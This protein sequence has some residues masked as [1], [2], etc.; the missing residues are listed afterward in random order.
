MAAL[1]PHF[2]EPYRTLL[3]QRGVVHGRVDNV[4]T[5]YSRDVAPIAP[6][7]ARELVAYRDS[8]YATEEGW[9]FANPATGRLP[10]GGNSEEAYSGGG[11]SGRH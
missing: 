3:V 9:L 4:K 11:K 8:H 2:R 7:L 1:L 6:E 5:E 10:S